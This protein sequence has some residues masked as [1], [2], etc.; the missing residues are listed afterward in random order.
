MTPSNPEIV[1]YPGDPNYGVTRCGRVFRI[2]KSKFGRHVPYEMKRRHDKDGY[3]LAGWVFKV[4]R[5][6]A[7]TFIPNTEGKP[8]VAHNDGQRDNNAVENL[9]WATV[10]ENAADT[11]AH[12]TRLKGSRHVT[13]K[14][15][16]DLVREARL[17]AAAGETHAALAEEFPVDRSVL[18]RAIRGDTWRHV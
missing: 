7:E 4:H 5:L 9:R 3:L 13:A 6:V 10:R 12:G 16:E 18:S 1:P 14:L 8:H 11:E 17:R 15:D 2:A